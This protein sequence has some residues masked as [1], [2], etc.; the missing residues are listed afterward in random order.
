MRKLGYLLAC[1]SLVFSLT[2][3]IGCQG[4]KSEEKTKAPVEK[5]IPAEE[6]PAPAEETP[7]P[8]EETPAPAE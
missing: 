8:A 2:V 1:F 4:K 7:A 3:S 5:A 6:T